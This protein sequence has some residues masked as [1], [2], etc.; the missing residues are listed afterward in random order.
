MNRFIIFLLAISFV[1]CLKGETIA[2]IETIDPPVFTYDAKVY[3]KVTGCHDLLAIEI[4]DNAEDFAYPLDSTIGTSPD[5]IVFAYNL[6]DSLKVPGM[7]I[8]IELEAAHGPVIYWGPNC[9]GGS[10]LYN[11]VKLLDAAPAV[12]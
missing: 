1:G 6:P 3:G 7:Y 2:E 5:N 9:W 8:T 12:E 4:L 11:Y 10:L